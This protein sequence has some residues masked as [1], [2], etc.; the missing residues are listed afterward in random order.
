[1]ATFITDHRRILDVFGVKVIA[2][3]RSRPLPVLVRER[4]EAADRVISRRP[5]S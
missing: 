5:S 3:L 2:L 4:T 1:M